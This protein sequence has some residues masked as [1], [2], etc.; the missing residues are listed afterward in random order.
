VPERG[1]YYLLVVSAHAQRG[2]DQIPRSMRAQVGRYFRFTP[3]S[4]GGQDYRWQAI[5]VERDRDVLVTFGKTTS[6]DTP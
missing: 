4:F 1:D 3:N 5:I 2:D 6:E